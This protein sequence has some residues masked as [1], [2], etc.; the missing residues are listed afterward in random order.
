PSPQAASDTTPPA[1]L[2]NLSAKEE[3]GLVSLSW[4]SLGDAS[5]YKI[6]RSLDEKDW[7]FLAEIDAPNYDDTSTEF[8]TKYFYR[9]AAVDAAGNIGEFATTS[10]IVKAFTANVLPGETAVI[11]SEDSRISYEIEF[12]TFGEDAT[13]TVAKSSVKAPKNTVIGP[14]VLSCKNK[15][16]D[17]LNEYKKPI[18]VVLQPAEKN[19]AGKLNVV[20]LSNGKSSTLPSVINKDQNNLSITISQPMVLA[21][22]KKGSGALLWLLLVAALAGI[23]GGY[24]VL[25]RRANGPA[26]NDGPLASPYIPTAKPKPPSSETPHYVADPLEEHPLQSARDRLNR[27]PSADKMPPP[28]QPT[29]PPNPTNNPDVTKTNDPDK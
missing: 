13:C 29:P 22:V 16:G 3:D 28:A 7:V 5:N 4:D 21:A 10:V 11:T 15:A 17:D 18:V 12:E 1:R 9:V 20:S 8:A 25:R 23:A 19:S 27:I 6:E 26:F 24:L 2:Q 14:Y